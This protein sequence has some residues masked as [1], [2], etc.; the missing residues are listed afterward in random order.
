MISR[1]DIALSGTK[2]CSCIGMS[3]CTPHESLNTFELFPVDAVFRHPP[4]ERLLGSDRTTLARTQN[5]P[6]FRIFRDDLQIARPSASW[7][8]SPLLVSLNVIDSEC[9]AR[10]VSIILEI[11]SGHS[12]YCSRKDCPN[13]Y[14]RAPPTPCRHRRLHLHT[15]RSK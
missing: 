12:P 3:M 4:V 2:P 11:Q 6:V 8:G 15:S 9:I 14:G 1:H 13:R 7:T 5:V 10:N